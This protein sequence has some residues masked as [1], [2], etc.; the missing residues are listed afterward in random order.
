M[1][2]VFVSFSTGG[3]GRPGSYRVLLVGVEVEAKYDDGCGP[4]LA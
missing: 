3:G 4:V 1:Q 2:A